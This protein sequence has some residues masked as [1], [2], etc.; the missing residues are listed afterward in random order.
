MKFL[1]P[2]YSCLQNPWLGGYHPQISVISVLNWICWTPPCEKNSWVRHCNRINLRDTGWEGVNRIQL[3]QE[4]K[5][6]WALV[7]IVMK[8][9]FH[10]MQE[11]YWLAY[12][13]YSML[14]I[15]SLLRCI[16]A[17]NVTY[18][19]N[20]NNNIIFI[21]CN[22]VVTRWQWLFYMYTNMKKKKVTRKF[23]SGGLHERHVVATWELGNH[24]SIRL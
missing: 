3:A 17:T 9:G 14:F 22:W 18:K 11:I 6:W 12:Q 4:R 16:C 10:K 21:N 19:N 1:V 8:L 13:V 15:Y 24:L 2:N 7:D 5:D 23:K 20:N